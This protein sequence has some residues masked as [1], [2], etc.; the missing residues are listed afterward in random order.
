[1]N[2]PTK[3][4]NIIYADPPWFYNPRH[5]EKATLRR[6][7]GGQYSLMKDEDIL[8][9]PIGDLAA[10]NCALLLW[11]TCPTLPLGIQVVEKWGFRYSTVAFTWIKVN[12]KSRTPFFGPGFY[13]ASNAELVLVGMR[14]SLKVM[15]NKISQVVIEERMEHSHKPAIIRE[16]IVRLFGDLPR[17]ELFARQTAPGWDGWGDMYEGAGRAEPVQNK[18]FGDVI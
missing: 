14:G 18:L 7:A 17:I 3:K 12:K 9:L 4:Y 11:V 13:T 16:L 8:K 15:D 1:M 6:G 2:L 5:N 10:K